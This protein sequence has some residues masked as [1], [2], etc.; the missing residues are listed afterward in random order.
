MT[1]H[2]Y[3]FIYYWLPLNFCCVLKLWWV[4]YSHLQQWVLF[5]TPIW[6]RRKL[7]P[8]KTDFPTYFGQ[9]KGRTRALTWMVHLTLLRSC[10]WRYKCHCSY[11]GFIYLAQYRCLSFFN[12]KCLHWGHLISRLIMVFDRRK[13]VLFKVVFAEFPSWHS[14]LQIRLGTMRLW[15]W[16][17]A[18]LSGLRIRCCCELWCRLQMLA[19]IPHCCGSGSDTGQWL[20]LWL[21]P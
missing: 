6:Q 4:L 15:L 18:L 14:G 13:K 10:S 16:S 17:L 5:I 11:L 20:Q 3:N 21:Y 8:R 7:G 19:Q 12:F 9:E 1:H 2:C